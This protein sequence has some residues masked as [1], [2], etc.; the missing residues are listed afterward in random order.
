ML[1][2]VKSFSDEN[3]TWCS[4]QWNLSSSPPFLSDNDAIDKTVSSSA[5]SL[6][7]RVAR[8]WSS[9]DLIDRLSRVNVRPASGRARAPPHKVLSS[10]EPITEF[11]PAPSTPPEVTSAATGSDN[12]GQTVGDVLRQ[13]VDF[14]VY[15]VEPVLIAE[16]LRRSRRS[17]PSKLPRWT[18]NTSPLL[19]STEQLRR[20]LTDI[21]TDT[22]SDEF[23]TFC[24]L[25]RKLDTDRQTAE[26]LEA[27]DLVL[28]VVGGCGCRCCL[29][30]A[31]GQDVD[32][33]RSSWDVHVV[34]ADCETRS[35]FDYRDVESIK[36]CRRRKS[37]L[38]AHQ[39]RPVVLLRDT[40]DRYGG[41]QRPPPPKAHSTFSPQKLRPKM[42][43]SPF[44]T[45]RRIHFIGGNAS[46]FL[47]IC[48]HSVI[49][50]EGHMS[51]RAPILV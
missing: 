23:S 6:R 12:V 49:I 9:R 30:R 13:T 19:M 41:T 48:N 34:Y 44:D 18:E 31:G 39:R 3:L 45:H 2:S 25:L 22:E 17:S 35:E 21:I 37:R 32:E 46:F 50:L 11:D 8:A 24:R 33:E 27:L 36:R 28:K 38:V 29:E 26:F 16:H 51:H 5:T 47:I 1:Y 40:A 10:F 14:L 43:N 4:Q 7:M 15:E 42:T 20:L